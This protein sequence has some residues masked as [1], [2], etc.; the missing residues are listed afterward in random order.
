MHHKTRLAARTER[1][2][3]WTECSLHLYRTKMLGFGIMWRWT[4]QRN[5]ALM[6]LHTHSTSACPQ[7]RWLSSGLECSILLARKRQNIIGNMNL[8]SEFPCLLCSVLFNVCAGSALIQSLDRNLGGTTPADVYGWL[9]L[10]YEIICVNGRACTSTYSI[11]H[12][13]SPLVYEI[14]L[15]FDTLVSHIPPLPRAQEDWSH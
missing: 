5:S 1:R 14:T 6:I 13:S 11:R 15:S 12:R 2:K 9:T 4:V 10:H 8:C 7:R 3:R